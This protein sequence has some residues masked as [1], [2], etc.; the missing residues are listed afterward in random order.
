MSF[1]SCPL[2]EDLLW[3]STCCS[4]F[5]IFLSFKNLSE[6]SRLPVSPQAVC[7]FLP[8]PSLTL[9]TKETFQINVFSS[10]KTFLQTFRSGAGRISS[11]SG[12]THVGAEWCEKGKEKTNPAQIPSPQ[13]DRQ[14]SVSLKWVFLRGGRVSLEGKDQ[15]NE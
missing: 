2:S 7:H 15:V 8:S 12:Q 11:G 13:V 3:I 5:S 4:P 10:L 1:G 6:T 14:C 9:S